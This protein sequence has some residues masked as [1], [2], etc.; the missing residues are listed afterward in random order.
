MFT[1][2]FVD[3]EPELCELYQ[4]IFASKQVVVKAFVSPSDMLI[5]I[6]L[7]RPHLVFLDYRMPGMRGDEVAKLLPEDIP[8]YMITGEANV[9]PDYQFV[10]IL[11]KPPDIDEIFKIIQKESDK[12]SA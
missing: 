9:R 6:K 10:K 8:K 11:D 7:S 1:V 4:D 12:I 5:E 2:F 3:D